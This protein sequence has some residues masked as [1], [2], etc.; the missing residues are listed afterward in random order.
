MKGGGSVLRKKKKGYCGVKKKVLGGNRKSCF[1][2][3]RTV[4]VVPKREARRSTS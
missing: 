4:L 1:S 3:G 2:E